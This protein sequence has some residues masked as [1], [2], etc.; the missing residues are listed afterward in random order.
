M[1]TRA[2][3]IVVWLA[4][5]V[6]VTV[7]ATDA[8]GQERTP[9]RPLASITVMGSATVA[10][11]PDTAEITTGVV[12]QARSADQALTANSAAMDTMLKALGG[13]GIAQKDI[14]TIGV[15][16]T[17]Q[18]RE[19][20]SDGQRPEI[21][22]YEVTNQVRVKVRDLSSLG[23]VLDE[24]VKQGANVVSGVRFGV[25]DPTRLLDDARTKA[26]ADALRKAELYAKAAGVK[27]GRPLVVE[28]MGPGWPRPGMAVHTMMATT[29][30]PIATGEEEFQ[31]TISVTYAIQ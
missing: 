15:T 20:R 28:E 5:A 10:A 12:T 2:M 24:Q 17:P 18:R 27:L 1:T 30:V 25:Q 29:G 19:G 31:A 6:M 13:L 3:G 8:V 7:A 23:R 26:M 11:P 4:G 22:G 16:V 21:L 9:R 14:Q